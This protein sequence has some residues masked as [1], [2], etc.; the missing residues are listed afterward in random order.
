MAISKVPRCPSRIEKSLIKYYSSIMLLI[1][2]LVCYV[3]Y[4]YYGC[5]L[6]IIQI[7]MIHFDN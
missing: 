7:S 3:T 5:F 2:I 6:K 4:N 1:T